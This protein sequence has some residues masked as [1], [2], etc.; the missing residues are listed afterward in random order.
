MSAEGCQQCAR[1]VCIRP[2]TGHTERASVGR[3]RSRDATHRADGRPH[4]GACAASLRR[5]LLLRR[6]HLRRHISLSVLNGDAEFLR[7]FLEFLQI[8][9]GA[10]TGGL[11]ALLEELGRVAR[12][13]LH[14]LLEVCEF[15]HGYIARGGG[16]GR[17]QGRRCVRGA[18]GRA[19]RTVG[20][21]W[22]ARVARGSSKMRFFLTIAR[23]LSR[24]PEYATPGCVAQRNSRIGPVHDPLKKR[25]R[26]A[27]GRPRVQ[28]FPAH[29]PSRPT[30]PRE[31]C[32][33]VRNHTPCA[34]S[35]SNPCFHPRPICVAVTAAHFSRHYFSISPHHRAKS[36]DLPPCLIGCFQIFPASPFLA[37]A[38]PII[39]PSFTPPPPLS[40]APRPLLRHCS[41]SHERFLPRFPRAHPR[42][43]C[44]LL[45]ASCAGV[46]F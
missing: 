29:E 11:V 19:V 45:R 14:G 43:K 12:D 31:F 38:A 36:P 20:R 9:A 6:G 30:T 2:R 40:R 18:P 35:R 44:S 1:G 16:A 15:V 17:Q 8:L 23:C 42:L 39:H 33:R 13:G 3:I 7:E 26:A 27:N 41:R 34:V 32:P 22:D 21:V 5:Y 46:V 28:P 25:P 37:S 10:R 24:M 4:E